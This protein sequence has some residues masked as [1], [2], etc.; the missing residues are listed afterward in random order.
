[1]AELWE[2]V[3]G[4]RPGRQGAQQITLFKSVGTGLQDLAVAG[5]LYRRAQERGLGQELG[6]FPRARG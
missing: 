3:S 4:R 5:A 1:V 6:D 2:V